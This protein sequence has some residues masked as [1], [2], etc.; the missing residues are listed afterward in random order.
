MGD[1]YNFLDFFK[2]YHSLRNNLCKK[3]NDLSEHFFVKGSVRQKGKEL[4]AHF[5]QNILI[6]G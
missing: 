2:F 6:A 4:Q 5:E 3:G 1:K